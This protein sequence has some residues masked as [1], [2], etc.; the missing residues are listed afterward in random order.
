MEEQLWLGTLFSDELY[1]SG[2]I[3]LSNRVMVP[4]S[5]MEWENK[6][7]TLPGSAGTAAD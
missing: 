3:T 2:Q 1:N 5:E 6:V 7:H 4:T